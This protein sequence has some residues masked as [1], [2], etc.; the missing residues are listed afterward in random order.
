MPGHVARCTRRTRRTLHVLASEHH[1]LPL[2][3]PGPRQQTPP[4]VVA[5]TYTRAPRARLAAACSWTQLTGQR[6]VV[7][8][9]TAAARAAPQSSRHLRSGRAQRAAGEAL[10]QAAAGAGASA[11][12]QHTRRPARGAPP[13]CQSQEASRAAPPT[14]ASR[15][16]LPPPAPPATPLSSICASDASSGSHEP[17]YLSRTLYIQSMSPA[18]THTPRAGDPRASRASLIDRGW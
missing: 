15:S 12:P 14:G 17:L 1:P 10:P 2:V 16:P 11:G 4:Y 18:S 5:R 3:A 9:G 7:L 6:L 8:D 13:G